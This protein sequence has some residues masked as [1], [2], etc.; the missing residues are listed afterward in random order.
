MGT[1]DLGKVPAER[2][3]FLKAQEAL[4]ELIAFRR[5]KEH[6]FISDYIDAAAYRERGNVKGLDSLLKDVE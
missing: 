6:L 3:G 1:L 2:E 4:K 5:A